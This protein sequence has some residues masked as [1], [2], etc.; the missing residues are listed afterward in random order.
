MAACMSH[1]TCRCIQNAASFPK[2]SARRTAESGVIARRPLMS[3][4]TR[5]REMPSACASSVWVI[6]SGFRKRDSR[7]SP[8]CGGLRERAD[9][10]AAAGSR[11]RAKP[12]PGSASARRSGHALGSSFQK[13]MPLII[14]PI[15]DSPL[16]MSSR[17]TM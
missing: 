10:S 8:G 6:E 17:N 13:R 4:L 7:N 9:G 5:R 12:L 3:S 16:M 14:V 1:A 15:T 2:Y 11:Q